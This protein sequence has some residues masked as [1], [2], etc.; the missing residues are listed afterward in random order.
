MQ[1]APA[2]RLLPQVVA[3]IWKEQLVCVCKPMELMVSGPVPV[4]VTLTVW[5]A[6]VE[7]QRTVPKLILVGDRVTA[8]AV[9]VPVKAMVCG[10]PAALSVITMLAVRVPVAVGL[11]TTVNVQLALTARVPEQPHDNTKSPGFA[12]LR[13]TELMTSG[14][15]PVFFTV[16]D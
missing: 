7:P 13:T 1:L 14:A 15:V 11:K 16:M 8:G 2:A 9:P 6:L 5:G 12:P 10:E 4:L 3:V